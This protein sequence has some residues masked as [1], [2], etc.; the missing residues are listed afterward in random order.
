MSVRFATLLLA[1]FLIQCATVPKRDLDEI[2][3]K[4]EAIRDFIGEDMYGPGGQEVLGVA[5]RALRQ[6]WQMDEGT[7]VGLEDLWAHSLQEGLILFNQPDR[8]WGRTT[9]EET[10]D[11]IGQTTVGPWQMTIWNIRDNYGPRY[12]VDPNWSNAEINSFCRRHPEIQAKMII[13]YIQ[14]SYESFGERSPYAIQRYFWLEAY[15]R[16]DIG[17]SDDWT[18]SPVAHPPAGGTWEDLTDEM[19]ADTGFYAKQVL[20]GTNYTDT[21]L[22][23]WLAVTGDTDA[24]RDV[25]RTWRDQRRIVIPEE[26]SNVRGEVI[27]GVNYV[28]TDVPGGFAISPDDVIYYNEFPEIQDEIRG[29]ITEI[30]EEDAE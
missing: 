15:V 22:L 29:L 1:V 11:M 10:A 6:Q 5:Y 26:G 3:R 18:R 20:M 4:Y 12:G 7:L 17:Q 24:I 28:L 2:D 27:E 16:G 21:G 13:D 8:L 14:L 25:L 30:A 9:A 23:F 19:K